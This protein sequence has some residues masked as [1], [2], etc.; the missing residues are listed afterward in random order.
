MCKDAGPLETLASA[1]AEN[2]NFKEAVEWQKK[3]I[4]LGVSQHFRAEEAQDRLKLYEE[5]KPYRQK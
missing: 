3:A 2:G 5:G 1:H 4:E